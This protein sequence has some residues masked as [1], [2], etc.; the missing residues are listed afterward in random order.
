[1]SNAQGARRPHDGERFV[2]IRPGALGDTLLT[3]PALALLRARKTGAH[4][5]FVARGDVLALARAS[6]LADATS[7]YDDPAW[8]ALFD[9]TPRGE[10]AYDVIEGSVVVAWLGDA[11][12]TVR[13][14]LGRLGAEEIIIAESRPGEGSGD[15]AALHLARTLAPLGVAAPDTAGE[16]VGLLP[17][18]RAPEVDEATAGAVWR[19]LGLPRGGRVVA[20]HAG[21][22]GAAKRWPPESFAEV[23]DGLG[24]AGLAPLLIGGPQDDEVTA[25]VL[26]AI[27][28][29]APP[30]AR[31]LSVGAVAAVLRRCA[32]YLGNDSGV[33]HLAALAGVPTVALFGPSDPALWSPLGSRVTVLRSA[34]G[35]MADIGVG[36]AMAGVRALLGGST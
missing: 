21:S 13:R 2:L 12:G 32:A 27:S 6:G 7:A 10:T 14:A 28:G 22:G 9:E 3:L 29:E 1:V 18:L 19:E 4:V 26:A 36:E 31:G 11:D 30:V 5:T 16:L 17:P 20:L 34:T 25:A 15:H 23:A 33:T 24:G 8:L 35:A